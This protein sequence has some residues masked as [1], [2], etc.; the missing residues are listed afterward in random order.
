MI[1]S[2]ASSIPASR[3][4]AKYDLA[5]DQ[6]EASK[7]MSSTIITARITI[8]GPHQKRNRAWPEHPQGNRVTDETRSLL[9]REV[10]SPVPQQLRFKVTRGCIF[11]PVK[12][13]G[14]SVDRMRAAP[15]SIPGVVLV[16]RHP[17]PG[18]A[19]RH[20]NLDLG[21]HLRD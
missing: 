12:L 20:S 5:E 13:R 17:G 2:V 15:T 1:S 19:Q 16:R 14:P 9:I 18:F 21:H 3:P 6:V 8:A 4:L 10:C 7:R 11:R